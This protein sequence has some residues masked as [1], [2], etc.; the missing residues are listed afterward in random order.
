MAI[1]RGFSWVEVPIYW[2][3]QLIGAFIGA[4]IVYITN[5][6]AINAAE[7]NDTIG[8]FSTGLQTPAV[9]TG[10]AFLSELFG[11][12]LLLI[13]IVSTSDT[14]NTPAGRTK[15]LIIGLSL[16]AIGISFGWETGFAVNPA[17]DL[18]P[19]IFAAIAGW[20]STAF[21]RQNYYF[22]VPIVAPLLRW[23][24]WSFQ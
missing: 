2:I 12:A 18:G 7:R 19:R 4:V 17:R 23:R 22:W 13:V 20:G 14:G 15:P 1:F 8:I 24:D 10:A 21:S 6:S 3:A 5:Y 16:V 11:T 9:S